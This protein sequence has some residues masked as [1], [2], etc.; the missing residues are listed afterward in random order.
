MPNAA[1]SECQLL[2]FSLPRAVFPVAINMGDFISRSNEFFT[3]V[4][5]PYRDDSVKGGGAPPQICV[6]R[7]FVMTLDADGTVWYPP[8]GEEPAGG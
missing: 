7:E 6:S 4:Y 8:S 3:A 2:Y 5:T 1:L